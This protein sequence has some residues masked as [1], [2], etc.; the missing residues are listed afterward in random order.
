MAGQRGTHSSLRHMTEKFKIQQAYSS[1]SAIDK[2]RALVFG[3]KGM[4]R[5]LGFELVMLLC[6]KRSGALGLFLRKHTYPW[7][8]GSVG[9]NVVFGTSITLRH[10]HKIHIGDNVVIDD[11][12]SLDAKGENNNGIM[13]KDGVFIGRNTILSCKDGDIT[14][15]ENANLGFN[16]VI[17]ST[18][19]V[20]VGRDNIVAA[21]TYLLGGGSYE[22]DNISTPIREN[23]D[24][25]GKGGVTTGNNV[26]IGA[27]VTV[28]DGVSIESGCVVGAGSVVSRSIKA[29]SVA[30]GSPARVIRK[31]HT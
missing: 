30:A 4:L 20:T 9:R 7:I 21:Y 1:G 31:R 22:F 17:S 8:L 3:R 6:S 24:Y 13:L 25:T 15:L 26:W 11:Y 19:S 27:H 28:L 2:Y 18:N 29:D 16:C 12:V 5:L 14:L 10:P 23:Y